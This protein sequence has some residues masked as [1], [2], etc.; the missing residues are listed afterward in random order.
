[1]GLQH[2]DEPSLFLQQVP[3]GRNSLDNHYQR[4]SGCQMDGHLLTIAT[5]FA[6]FFSLKLVATEANKNNKS[7]S[8]FP[9]TE[10]TSCS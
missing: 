9:E 6:T 8:V 4:Q 2:N 10:L 3:C 5:V 1:M 7:C